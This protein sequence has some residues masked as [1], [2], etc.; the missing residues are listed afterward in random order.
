[1]AGSLEHVG[2]GKWNADDLADALAAKD[3]TRCGQVAPPQGL[4]LVAVDYPPEIWID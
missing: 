2:A 4:Y 3:R 1:M